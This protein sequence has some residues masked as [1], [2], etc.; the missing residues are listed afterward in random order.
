L[1]LL[2]DV[3]LRLLSGV[4][5]AVD[6]ASDI[7][8]AS[9]LLSDVD[10]AVETVAPSVG[11]TGVANRA[12]HGS[13]RTGLRCSGKGLVGS[14]SDKGTVAVDGRASVDKGIGLSRLHGHALV[15]VTRHS[16]TTHVRHVHLLARHRWT[17]HL[18]VVHLGVLEVRAVHLGSVHLTAVRSIHVVAVHLV[19]VLVR[20]ELLRG[21]HVVA[22]HVIAVGEMAAASEAVVHVVEAVVNRAA[23]RRTSQV[24]VAH[25][26]R[27]GGHA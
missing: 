20:S 7:D 27:H 2:S 13:R 22:V 11:S 19:V 25:H 5:R 9:D 17:T 10:R 15:D 3:V 12:T 16:K 6:L 23:N 1:G 14:G 26:A 18:G 4:D 21:V 8:R 24:H